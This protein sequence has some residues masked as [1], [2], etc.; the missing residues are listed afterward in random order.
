MHGDTFPIP[1]SLIRVQPIRTKVL[2]SM[3]DFIPNYCREHRAPHLLN[4]HELNDLVRDLNFDNGKSELL[5]LQQWNLLQS[6]TKIVSIGI[7]VTFC[8]LFS[9]WT[10]S[11]CLCHN[12]EGLL[13]KHGRPKDHSEKIYCKNEVFHFRIV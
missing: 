9:T 7:A 13:L 12:I 5:A 3:P 6:G 8:R 10:V 11:I 2:M 4:Q 1:I